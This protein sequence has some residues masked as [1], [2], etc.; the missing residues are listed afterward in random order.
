ME[1]QLTPTP[2]IFSEN[3]SLKKTSSSKSINEGVLGNNSSKSRSV[4]S[5][6]SQNPKQQG[7]KGI[8]GNK[9]TKTKFV[10]YEDEGEAIE[11]F[12]ISKEKREIPMFTFRDDDGI[13]KETNFSIEDNL[14]KLTGFPN[15]SQ[16]Q[17]T[18]NKRKKKLD[19]IENELTQLM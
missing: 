13:L 2:L 18:F 12:H 3:T 10:M 1:N 9:K 5:D 19:S 15:K 6:L 4:F 8:K 14:D 16:N 17:R 7:F 11:Q